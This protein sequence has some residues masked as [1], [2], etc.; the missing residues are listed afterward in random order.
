MV[1][2]F[3]YQETTDA[4]HLFTLADSYA[5][6]K[7]FIRTWRVPEPVPDSIKIAVLTEDIFI[8]PFTENPKDYYD[9]PELCSEYL[10]WNIEKH[11]AHSQTVRYDS[12]NKYYR[13]FNSI[14][15]PYHTYFENTNP[16]PERLQ[17][18]GFWR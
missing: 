5:T 15:L 17:V 8:D 16:L 7:F 3:D 10:I 1:G 18:V 2:L 13:P 4:F 11:T 14:Y 12:E 9:D 6:S